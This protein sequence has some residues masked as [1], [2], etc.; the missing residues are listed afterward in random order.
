MTDPR[1]ELTLRLERALKGQY[2][3]VRELG[4][5]GMGVVYE[6]VDEALLRPVAIKV[7]HPELSANP[8]T[9]HRFLEEA[10][11]IARLKHPNIVRIHA[12]GQADG[13]VY[14]V[15]E[16]VEGRTLR[17]ELLRTGQLPPDRARRIA[18][19]IALALAA[20]GKAGIVHRDVKPENI[21]LEE[22]TGDALLVDFGIACM[23]AIPPFPTPNTQHLAP[24]LTMGT[25]AYMSPEQAAGDPVDVRSDLYAL[26]IVLYEMLAGRPPFHGTRRVVLSRQIVDPLPPV[27]TW[28][29]GLPPDLVSAV[30]RALEKIPDAR[31]QC[32]EEFR[33]ALLNPP[34]A[35]RL[36]RVSSRLRRAAVSLAVAAA[37][38]FA[39]LARTPGPGELPPEGN[40]NSVLILPFANIRGDGES[41]WLRHGSVSMLA[42]ALGQWREITVV[43]HDRLH[44]LLSRHNLP[45][46]AVIGLS[47]A[48]R[49][50]RDIGVQTVVLGDFTRLGD[51]VQLVARAWDVESGQRQEQARV[52]GP[53]T[54]DIRVLFDDLAARLLDL[55]VATEDRGPGISL[56]A[57][58]TASLSAYRQYLRG[59]E[60]L[61][62]WRLGEAELAFREAVETDSTF[63]LAYYQLA[64]TR[65]WRAGPEDPAGREAILQAGRFGDRLSSRERQAVEAYRAMTDNEPARARDLYAHLVA[66]DS[67][68][69]SAWYGL[70]DA[71]FHHGPDATPAEAMTASLRAFQ[72]AIA[73]EPRN[74]L[75][76]EHVTGLLT[77]TARADGDLLLMPGSRIVGVDPDRRDSPPVRLARSRAGRAAVEAARDWVTAQPRLDR[78][79]RAL[80]EAHVT[81]GDYPAATR[82][83]RQLR[84]LLGAPLRPLAGFLEARVQFAAGEGSRARA[85]LD[86]T[87]R[88]VRPDSMVARSGL[89]EVLVADVLASAN[90]YAHAGDLEGAETV[91]LLADSLR[92]GIL[93]TTAP[94]STRP[95]V[96]KDSRLA[97]LYSAT[98]GSLYQLRGLW[99]NVLRAAVVLPREDR[100]KVAWAGAAAAQGLFLGASADTVALD[101]LADLTGTT[102]PKAIR[103]LRALSQGDSTRARSVLSEE[104]P[105]PDAPGAM[106]EW[107][108]PSAFAMGDLRPVTAEAHFLLGN[109]RETLRTLDGFEP[110]HFSTRYFDSR[111]GL[112]A[113]VTLLRGMAWERLGETTL[114]DAA[115]SNVLAQWNEADEA[116]YP[117]LRM[118][119][120]GR[121]RL[122]GLV[123][124]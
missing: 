7:V 114:A 96:W 93:A 64:V 99:Q 119:Q 16:A 55:T 14:Y 104:R 79:R 32:P 24:K 121:E 107:N 66:A 41:D 118:A 68:D 61:N 95:D 94:G 77:E 38:L 90:V 83:V 91:I 27:T 87:L 89:S 12:V 50:A 4:R 86:R 123:A 97:Q 74:S 9:V 19:D 92:Q 22:G 51:S 44:D 56:A 73:L 81:V 5:G 71:W 53:V 105:D 60:A 111:W 6:A 34:P 1:S 11:V 85:I 88:E 21:L 35:T 101:Q 36:I 58:T 78:A 28:R 30:A 29:P 52:D 23:A 25:P 84:E 43:D 65:G 112:L 80:F 33:S 37:A 42:L 115:Y 49:I 102:H 76:R 17:E 75:A 62:Q 57:R 59:T 40:R 15:M 124:G 103:A 108:P 10:R 70:G 117:V 63:G 67:S 110:A 2:R 3:L 98:G 106:P 45:P 82:D 69:A 116:L 100:A 20:A 26:G 46:D 120:A 113:R 8:A 47:E 72:R 13:L 39:L 48:R 18:G 109:Y 122:R 31:W 54:G